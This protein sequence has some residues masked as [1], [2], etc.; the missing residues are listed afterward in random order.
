MNKNNVSFNNYYN[1]DKYN[2]QILKEIKIKQ[3]FM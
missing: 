2:N 3:Y 1:V